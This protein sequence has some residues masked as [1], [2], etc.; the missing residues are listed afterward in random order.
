MGQS[1]VGAFGP[2]EKI[3]SRSHRVAATVTAVRGNL[4]SY[5]VA[6]SQQHAGRG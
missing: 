1:L 3:G 2:E 6:E 4:R 5:V